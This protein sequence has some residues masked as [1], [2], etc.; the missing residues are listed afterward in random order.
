MEGSVT[1]AVYCRA[2]RLSTAQHNYMA[3][4]ASTVA[5]YNVAQ[6]KALH[7]TAQRPEST[8]VR[9]TNMEKCSKLLECTKTKSATIALERGDS[10]H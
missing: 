9:V 3:G 4:H 8:I 7:S 10:K 5:Q 2:S 6:H 1:C